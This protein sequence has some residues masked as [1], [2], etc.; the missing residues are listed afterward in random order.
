[1]CLK[2]LLI[3]C[4]IKNKDKEIKQVTY[5]IHTK[6]TAVSE[7]AATSADKNLHH[8]FILSQ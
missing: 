5:E 3:M 4:Y 8:P 7:R 2:E 6:E 1:M